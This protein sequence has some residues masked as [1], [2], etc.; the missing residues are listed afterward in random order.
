ML[1]N[2][3]LLFFTFFVVKTVAQE[4]LSDGL[5]KIFSNAQSKNVN[6]NNID[7]ND[8]LG[9]V[10]LP[11]KEGTNLKA[12][13]PMFVSQDASIIIT[14]K[15]AVNFSKGA[16]TYTASTPNGE[17]KIQVDAYVA[18][19][20]VLKGFY[21]DPDILYSH[22]DKKFYI[23]PTS[24]GFQNWSGTYF[25]VFSSIDLTSWKDE[26]VILDLTKDVTWANRNAWAPSAIERNENGKYHYYFYFTAAQKIGVATADNPRGPFKD[27]GKA[28]IDFKPE[29][30]HNG[31]EIDPMVFADPVS[32][33][34]YLYW[35]N[36]YLAAAELNDDMIS[37]KRETLRVIPTDKT[38]REGTYVFFRKGIYYFMW[39]EDDT[40]SPNYKVRYGTSSSPMGP[41]TIANDNIVIRRNLKQQIHGTGHHAVINIPATDKWFLVYHRFNYPKGITMGRDAGFNREV[42]IDHL[43]F[44]SNGKIIEVIPTLEGVGGTK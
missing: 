32:K 8:S 11:V 33:K 7:C 6:M 1:K 13:D 3:A 28:L 9:L 12:L 10:R 4:K 24:D 38:F 41:V 26:G 42:C 34:H 27:S 40:R 22:K 5:C 29:G 23:Y 36:G 20:P 16:V 25:K 15:G 37:I 14:P 21:A 17:V 44:D 30:I 19:N 2:L 39:S 18:R 31:Q 43:T 35:G